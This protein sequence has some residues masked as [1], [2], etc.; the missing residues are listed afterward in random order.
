MCRGIMRIVIGSDHGGFELKQQLIE[1]LSAQ[2]HNVIDMGPDTP[3]AV[4]YPSI[5]F[6]VSE[7]VAGNKGDLGILLCGTGIGMCNAAGKVR[8][9]I[10]ALCTN[11][12]MAKMARKHNDANILCLGARVIGLELAK[13]IVA[14]FLCNEPQMEDKYVRRRGMI[15]EY[16]RDLTL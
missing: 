12:F 2:D 5:A 6:K 8:G 11:E 1:H 15:D 4:D 9:I 7:T 10:P 3:D 14:A 13:E 16:E